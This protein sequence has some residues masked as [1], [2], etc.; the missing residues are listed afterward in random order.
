MKKSAFLIFITC[1]VCMVL[2]CEANNGKSIYL[3]DNFTEGTVLMN[4]KAKINTLL[5]YDAA[6]RQM[7]YKDGDEIMI[8]VNTQSVD[9]VFI[10]ERRFI[11]A[12]RIFLEVVPLE[13]GKAF[14]NWK[15]KEKYQGKKGAFGQTTQT[16]VTTINTN[17]FKGGT[18]ER[19]TADVINI[20]NENEYW[21]PHKG[22]FSKFKTLKQVYKLFPD[23]EANIAQF[24][25]ANA[26]DPKQVDDMLKTINYMLHHSSNN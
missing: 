5:N 9:T 22:S 15:L 4:N 21:I 10:G 3:F 20:I 19:E 25:K 14:I 1:F 13:N 23:K 2:P 17:H 18:Y 26:I 11:P 6:N 24:V 7:K 16:N 12:G 8:L